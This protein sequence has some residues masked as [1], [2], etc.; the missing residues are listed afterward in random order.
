M[1]GDVFVAGTVPDFGVAVAL[2]GED[3]GIA[4]DGEEGVDVC[5]GGLESLAGSDV[6][7]AGEVI[8]LGGLEEDAFSPA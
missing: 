4:V 5:A 2:C 8:P 3:E 7:D 1:Q 6:A